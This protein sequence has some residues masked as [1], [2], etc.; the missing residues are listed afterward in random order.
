LTLANIIERISDDLE[1]DTEDAAYGVAD[2]TKPNKPKESHVTRDIMV[3]AVG[4]IAAAIGA[5]VL[6]L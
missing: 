4:G 6:G 5:K 1:T 2:V 3:N